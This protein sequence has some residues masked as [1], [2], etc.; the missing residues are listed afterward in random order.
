MTG[1][2]VLLRFALLGRTLRRCGRDQPVR[3]SALG[4]RA[5]GRAPHTPFQLSA[6]LVCLV[7][8]DS[9]HDG[10]D[11]EH[12]LCPVDENGIG[13][14]PVDFASLRIVLGED[15]VANRSQDVRDLEASAAPRD[16]KDLCGARKDATRNPQ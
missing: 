8:H 9:L 10:A 14:G 13:H 12:A 3:S 1:R 2:A 16:E 6:L 11:D 7:R 15:D 5:T 4:E